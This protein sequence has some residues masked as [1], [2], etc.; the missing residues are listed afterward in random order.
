V[1]LE[2]RSVIAPPPSVH[3]WTA[4]AFPWRWRS[5]RG[6]RLGAFVAA[7]ACGVALAG[8]PVPPATVAG[9]A[10]MLGAAIGQI[11]A[12]Q[13]IRWEASRGNIADLVLGRRV[14]FLASEQPNGPRDAWRAA[15]RVTPDGRLLDVADT[16]NLTGTPLGD[17]HALVA[18][19]EYA[20]FA[21]LAFGQEQS[22]SLLDLRGLPTASPLS[23]LERITRWLTNVQETGGGE[24]IGR[25]DITLDQ[26]AVAVGL[27]IRDGRLAVDLLDPG[28]TRRHVEVDCDKGELFSA[29]PREGSQI[30]GDPGSAAASDGPHGMHLETVRHLPK[31]FILWAV[32]SARAVSWIGPAPVAW[33][34]EH[35]FAVQDEIRRLAFKAHGADATETLAEVAIAPVPTPAAVLDA[36]QASEEGHWPPESVA[37]IWKT[38]EPGEGVWVV[39]HAPWIK[40]ADPSAPPPFVRTF[41]RPDPDRPYTRVILVAMDMRQLDLAMEAGTEDPKPLTGGHGPGR[42]PRTP[43]IFSRVVAAFN[44]AFKTEHGGYGMM[45]HKRVLLP[46][47]PNAASVVVL[48]DQRVGF[49]TWA[50]TH[51]VGRIRGIDPDEIDS[52]RQNL[53]PLVDRGEVNPLGRSIWGYTL[54]GQGMQT[55]RTALCVTTAGHLVYAWGDDVSGTALGKAMKMG[56]CSYAMHLDMNPH[57]TGFIFANI[58]DLRTKSYKSELLSPLMTVSPERYIEYAPKDFFYVLVHDPTPP[59]VANVAWRADGLE[60]PPAWAPA[61]WSMRLPGDGAAVDL[62]DIESGRAT[63]RIRAGASEPDSKTGAIP[64]HEL[65]DADAHKVMLAIGLGRS[66]D[67]RPRGLATDGRLAYPLASLRDGAE[68]GGELAVLVAPSNGAISILKGEELISIAPHTDVAEVPLVLDAGALTSEAR[69]RGFDGQ[70]YAL[71]IT[72][73]GRVIVAHTVGTSD[74]PLAEALRRTGCSRAV[75]LDRGDHSPSFVHRAGS[76]TP[77]R[78]RYD[79]SVLYALAAPLAP[80]AFRFEPDMT[81]ADASKAK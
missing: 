39:P 18:E 30:P 25:V 56:G 59:P 65:D 51:E 72:V 77:P 45:V 70:R 57:H 22:V 50:D 28:G 79:D 2:S 6:W 80:R 63:F 27:A 23:R 41:V 54:P 12:P 3:S 8:P 10:D 35:V 15:V 73:T 43:A 36:S 17:D 75:A 69:R 34:E 58:D 11:V 9:L 64:L 49:G 42:I 37:S 26:P 67:K 29:D 19:G 13:D 7:F 33:L 66:T 61:L 16:H 38:L 76:D 60:P 71:G 74:E 24:G 81:V 48:E 20:A 21:T 5:A 46:P 52:F 40:R 44:G 62:L 32:D 55:E 31:R 1:T 14:L 47:Q 53:D 68:K 4:L 78:G